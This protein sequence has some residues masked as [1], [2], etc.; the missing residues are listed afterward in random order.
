[1]APQSPAAEQSAPAMV[2]LVSFANMFSVGTVY[3]LS[4]LQAELPRL[5]DTSHAWSS[6]PFAAACLGL[7]V[8]VASC[9]AVMA[10]VGARST[11]AAGTGLWGL[12]VVGTGISLDCINLTSL[13]ACLAVGGIGVGWTYLA[14]VVLVGQAF[15]PH[16]RLR[17]AIGPLGFSSGSAVCFALALILD[18]ESLDA[19]SLGR[20]LKLGGVA[21]CVVGVTT[22]AVLP[23]D[24]DKSKPDNDERCQQKPSVMAFEDFLLFF[25]A[26]P[27]MVVFSTLWGTAS[28]HGQGFAARQVLPYFMVALALGG[29]MAPV[30]AVRPRL[31]FL[32]LFYIRGAALLAFSKW[33]GLLTAVIA[34]SMVLFGHGAGFGILPGLIKAKEPDAARFRARYG[35]TLVAWGAAGIVS[36]VITGLLVSPPGDGSSVSFVAGLSILSFAVYMQLTNALQ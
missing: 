3:A 29:F 20:L 30:L 14:V 12:A 16:S 23:N 34:L 2:A 27:G 33:P 28:Y 21:F 26:L 5:L 32:A 9:A 18:I 6:L 19:E 13:L 36:F 24:K 17:S 8:G 11:A 22:Q 15:P 4:A 1:M 7:S 31:A 10:R 35:R 25:N